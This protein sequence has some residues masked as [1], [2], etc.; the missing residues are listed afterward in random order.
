MIYWNIV[1]GGKDKMSLQYI[2]GQ[3]GTPNPVNN[4]KCSKCGKCLRCEGD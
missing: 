1:D 3:C 2:C 4:L